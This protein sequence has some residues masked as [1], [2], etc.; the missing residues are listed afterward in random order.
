MRRTITA[1]RYAAVCAAAALIP[2]AAS[3]AAGAS[4][5]PKPFVDKWAE[6]STNHLAKAKGTQIIT[7]KGKKVVWHLA[8]KVWDLDPGGNCAILQFHT[9]KVI[10]TTAPDPDFKN[11]PSKSF[12]QCGKGSKKFDFKFIGVDQVAS[13]VCQIGR[14]GTRPFKCSHTVG[15]N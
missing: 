9:K 13:R 12:K 10:Q 4:T 3:T 7:T 5:A 1:F 6:S 2:L 14:H 11:G 15:F 8:G